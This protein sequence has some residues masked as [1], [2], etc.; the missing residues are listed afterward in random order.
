[1][2]LLFENSSLNLGG[3]R[4]W[5]SALLSFMPI[6]R[7]LTLK[8]LKELSKKSLETTLFNMLLT[9]KEITTWV[10]KHKDSN[11][12]MALFATSIPAAQRHIWQTPSKH[13]KRCKSG[14]FVHPQRWFNE[15][16]LSSRQA[17]GAMLAG[18]IFHVLENVS[19]LAD[20]ERKIGQLVAPWILVENIKVIGK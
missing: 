7:V 20:N 5:S 1:M 3:I 18:D 4:V 19:G 17:H 9:L 12:N 13:W 15:P 16:A 10:L 8:N 2:E 14:L 11:S 6:G